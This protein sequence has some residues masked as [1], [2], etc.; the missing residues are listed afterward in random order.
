MKTRLYDEYIRRLLL[1]NNED[2]SE[3]E[4]QIYRAE[5]R[6]W[7]QGVEDTKDYRFN[8]DYYYI[9]LFSKGVMPE[10]PICCGEFSDWKSKLKKE[11]DMNQNP[12]KSIYEKYDP[13]CRKCGDPLT[14]EELICGDC[15]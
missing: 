1:A 14:T 13:V 2:I 9:D 3:N 5:L 4:H 12:L 11:R 6:G 15:S 7:L 8:G 10:R